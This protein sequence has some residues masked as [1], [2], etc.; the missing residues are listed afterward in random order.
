MNW[1]PLFLTFR[2]RG[3]RRRF[4]CWIPLFLLW[5]PLLVIGLALVPLVIAASILM[6]PTRR[7]RMLLRAGPAFYGVVTALRGLKVDVQGRRESVYISF[8]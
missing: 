7:G 5:L 4:G 1:P 2:I 8:W 6:L 3:S